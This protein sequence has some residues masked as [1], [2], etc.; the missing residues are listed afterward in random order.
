MVLTSVFLQQQI[1][2]ST[3]SSLLNQGQVCCAGAM[4]GILPGEGSGLKDGPGHSCPRLLLSGSP[5]RP[6]PGDITCGGDRGVAGQSTHGRA[7]WSPLAGGLL[8]ANPAHSLPVTS[9]RCDGTPSSDPRSP[10]LPQ[11]SVSPPPTTPV[12]S[13]RFSPLAATP[14]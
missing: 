2:S 8:A 4:A 5:A 9:P 10:Q 1:P 7:G 13:A 14:G 12:L 6:F 3:A 11:G